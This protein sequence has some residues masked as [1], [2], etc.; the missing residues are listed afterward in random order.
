MICTALA[1][2]K[3]LGSKTKG[4]K[5]GRKGI[6]PVSVATNVRVMSLDFLLRPEEAITWFDPLKKMTIAQFLSNVDFGSADYLIIDL[7]PGTGAESYAVLQCTPDLDGTVIVTLPS[8]SP[9]VVTRRSIGL[10]RQAMFLFSVSL[11]I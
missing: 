4:L 10:C 11:K 3:I 5:I 7:P 2:P 8:E 6:V 1:Y 9:Q